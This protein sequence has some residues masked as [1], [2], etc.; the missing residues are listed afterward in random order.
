MNEPQVVFF[1]MAAAVIVLIG[2]SKG[3][4]GAGLGALAT[5]LMALVMA[6]EQAIGLILPLLMITD[7]FAVTVHWGRW[8]R[9]LV[10]LLLPGSVVGVTL[11]TFLITHVSSTTLRHGLGIIVLLFV[12]YKLFEKRILG[13]LTYHAQNWHGVLSG[14]VAGFS[15]SMAHTGGPPITIYLLMQDLTP[16]GFI[17]TSALYFMILNWIKVPYYAYAHLFH[18]EQLF[19]ILWLLPLIP[20]AVWIGKWVVVRVDKLLFERII[21][22][23]LAISALLLFL[24]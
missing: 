7:I 22:V 23:L 2:L 1:G 12:V 4:L 14:T 18:L 11:G 5:P 15:S 3:G 10:L 13:S 8:D 20:V 17:A 9:R 16:R 21:I 19:Q 6:P 24:E